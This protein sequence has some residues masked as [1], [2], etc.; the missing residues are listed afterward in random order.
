[1]RVLFDTNIML[2]LLLDREPHAE[3]AAFLLSAAE[4]GLLDGLLTATSATTIFYLVGRAAGRSAAHSSLRSL[5]PLL[6]VAAVDGPVLQAAIASDF[7]DFEHAVVHE[8]AL[9]AGAAGIVTR[10]RL[11]FVGARVA[12]YSPDELSAIVRALAD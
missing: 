7:S 2:D 1:M 4:R 6:E 9:A 5:L 10:D 8:A 12:I 11:G 3:S